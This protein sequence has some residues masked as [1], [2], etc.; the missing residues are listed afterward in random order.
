LKDARDRCF[1]KE[2][3]PNTDIKKKKNNEKT[4]FLCKKFGHIRKLLYFCRLFVAVEWLDTRL[5][6]RR[7][8]QKLLLT[9]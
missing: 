8:K 1:F 4:K 3:Q 2:K 6:I 9:N 7:E 5:V